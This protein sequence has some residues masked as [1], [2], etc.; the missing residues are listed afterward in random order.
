[1]QS[2]V[3]KEIKKKKKKKEKFEEK[4]SENFPE[5]RKD[6]K[7]HIQEALKNLSIIKTENPIQSHH[8]K[9]DEAKW[10]NLKIRQNI[11]TDDSLI[12]MMELN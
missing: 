4:M 11:L 3:Q 1:M 8:I 10:E 12:E 6:S 7:S 5:P 9:P 2:E